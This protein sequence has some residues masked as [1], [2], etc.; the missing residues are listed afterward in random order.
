MIEPGMH[1]Q[2]KGGD[3]RV[4]KRIE[5]PAIPQ[6]SPIFISGYF[7]VVDFGKPNQP[8]YHHVG[9]DQRCTCE[10]GAACPAVKAVAEYLRNGG[11]RAPDLPAGFYP[12]APQVC[13]ICGASTTYL[14]ELDSPHRGAGWSCTTGGKSHY[15]QAHVQ[16]LS[17]NLKR[18]PWLIPP[19]Y[20][21]DGQVL[22]PGVRRS[23]V[24][25]ET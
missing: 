22:H 20:A 1:D 18:N 23:E 3:T 19:I 25:S 17:E 2:K 21:P 16:V 11:E 7:Y 4:S 14:A 9:K 15:W 13:P 5:Q 12:V 10:K 24:I 8:D 6:Q